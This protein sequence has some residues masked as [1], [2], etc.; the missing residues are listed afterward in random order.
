M[1]VAIDRDLTRAPLPMIP[2][3]REPTPASGKKSDATDGATFFGGSSAKRAILEGI[4][5]STDAK[6]CEAST[7]SIGDFDLMQGG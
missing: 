2:L 1:M 6:H 5:M 4:E 3:N 7:L